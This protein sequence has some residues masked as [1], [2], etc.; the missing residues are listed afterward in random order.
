MLSL[1]IPPL[2][3]ADVGYVQ[4][5]IGPAKCGP[6][7]GVFGPHT[8]AG[9]IWYQSMRGITADGVVGRVTWANM[10]VTLRT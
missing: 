6:D 5:F 10:G 1:A 3:G 2:V 8:R 7:D 9:V 4:R